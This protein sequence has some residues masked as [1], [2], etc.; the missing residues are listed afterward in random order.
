MHAGLALAHSVKEIS[1]GAAAIAI[2][3]ALALGWY[4][5]WW[6]IAEHNEITAR[7][8]LENAVR[9]MWATRRAVVVAVIAGVVLVDLWFRG[10]GH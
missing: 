10:K 1:T 7:Q 9:L 4:G 3:A 2:T 8:R 6:W 5:A